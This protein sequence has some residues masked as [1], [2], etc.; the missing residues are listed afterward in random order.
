[1]QRFLSG[2]SDLLARA[3]QA[4]VDYYTTLSGSDLRADGRFTDDGMMATV[5][6]LS[7]DVAALTE[8]KTLSDSLGNAATAMTYFVMSNGMLSS[9]QSYGLS[10]AEDD[11]RKSAYAEILDASVDASTST[12]ESFAVQLEADGYA[13]GYPLWST[14]WAT[15][16][17]TNYRGTPQAAN[18][19][20]V[21]LNEAWY[22]AIGLFMMTALTS[23]E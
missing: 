16:A 5:D 3:G 17:A 20:W 15:A 14:R 21:A 23:E 12:V 1:M 10:I 11:L 8:P 9:G 6:Q 2:Y 19:A 13:I 22:D 18:A 7:E 4:N